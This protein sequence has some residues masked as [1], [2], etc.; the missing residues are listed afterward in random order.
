MRASWKKYSLKF[1]R[2]ARTSRGEMTEHTVYYIQLSENDKVSWG[3]TAPLPGLSIDDLDALELKLDICCNLINEG[4]PIDL[5]PTDGFPSIEFG[6]ETA[7]LSH[8]RKNPFEVFQTPFYFQN[9]NIPINGLVWMDTREGMF[10]QAIEKYEKGFK[11]IKFKV[12][13]LDFDEECR[14]LESVRKR[15]NA[16]NM[17]IRLDANG[18]FK[19]D[20]VFKKL[21]ELSRFEVHSIEQPIKQGQWDM[22]QE[23]CAKSPIGVAL[24]E[25]LIGID[26]LQISNLLKHISPPFIILKPTLLG[27]FKKSNQWINT[28]QELGIDWWATSALESNIGLNAIAQW[29]SSYELKIPQGL[30]TGGLYQNNIP[31]PLFVSAGEI[32]YNAGQSWDL[33]SIMET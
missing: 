10:D 15:A 16:F 33:K 22:M 3:E 17:E 9:K 30:G 23:I 31:S 1:V 14:L 32:G 12:G 5:L 6:F 19:N 21:K 26:S 4:L 11:C 7:H 2:P 18:A 24:D 8:A 20:D 13:A 28:A 27:G 25:E 29:C